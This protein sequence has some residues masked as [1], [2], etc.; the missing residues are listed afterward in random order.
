MRKKK[1]IDAFYPLGSEA[2]NETDGRGLRSR[3]TREKIRITAGK[4]FVENGIEN[5]TVDRI[6]QEAGIS[7][8]TFYLH[9]AC[10]DDVILEYAERRLV[11][12]AKLLPELSK[13]HSTL[14]AIRR[15]ISILLKERNWNQNLVRS[16]LLQLEANYDRLHTR[17][18]RQLLLPQI[19]LGI[20]RGEIRSDLPPGTLASFV[21]DA[22]YNALRNWGM[23]R[24]GDDL[25]KALD[26][27]V[28]LVFDAIRRR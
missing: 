6:V 28:D 19:N 20:S 9:F 13:R 16:V 12:A 15:L 7:K 17:D 23:E 11:L 1:K 24:T 4:L 25:D 14:E 22:I 2:D 27:T 8:G 3:R 10:K 26:Y 5:T 18:L 21:T